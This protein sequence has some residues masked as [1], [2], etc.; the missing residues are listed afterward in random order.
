MP[1][2]Q[3]NRY[4]ADE[5]FALTPQ[6]SERT[7]L[8][9]GKIVT[10]TASGVIHQDIAGGIYAEIRQFIRNKK[11]NCKPFIAPFDVK[12][13][14]DTVV[15]PDVLVVCD[16]SCLDVTAFKMVAPSGAIIKLGEVN[17]T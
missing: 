14:D 7:E 2:H 1:L 4:T 11:G 10:Q 16:T 9:D 17:D 8:I 5:Y 6:T 12:L 3:K 15:Q 13:T